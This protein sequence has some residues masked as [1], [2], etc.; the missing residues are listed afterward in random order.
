M[1]DSVPPSKP[2]LDATPS[3]PESE[4]PSPAPPPSKAPVSKAPRSKRATGRPLYFNIASHIGGL[5]V[6]LAAILILISLLTHFTTG[7]LNP[8]IGI[9][10]YMVFPALL[11]FGVLLFLLGMRWEAGR[12]KKLHSLD[13][14]PY[15][16]IDLNDEHQRRVF[17]YSSVGGV[18]V[19][20]LIVW[21][22]YQGFHFTES[23]YFCGQLCH[24]PMQPEFT[25]HRDSPHARVRCTECHVGEG[26]SW[27]VRSKL[28]GARQV[29]AVLSN[30]YQR[31]IPTP[32]PH[33]RPAR[34]TCEQ[35]HWPEKFFGATL[36]QLPHFR[37]TE[38]NDAEQ[39]SLTLK[40][41]G[42]SRA[43]GKSQ[44]IHWHMVVSNVVTYAASDAKLQVIPWVKV[45][46]VDGSEKTYVARKTK[47][48]PEKLE[49]LPKRQ[50]D[51]MDCHNRPA[52][53]FP[54]PDSG[55]DEALLKG[56]IPADLPW[57]K[58]ITVE[59]LFQEYPSQDAARDGIR[60]YI[61]DFYEH[62]YPKVFS[63]RKAELDN[64]VAVAN[65][66]YDRGVFPKM[67]VDWQ[68]YPVD[69]GHRYWPGCFRCHDGK[70]VAQDGTVLAHDCNST[71]HSAP[72]RGKVTSLGKVDE[73]ATPDWH[74]WRMPKEHL[75]IEGHDM[76]MCFQC[77]GAGKRPSKECNDCHEK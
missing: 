29:L 37:Y 2:E 25:A 45:R 57:V 7:T 42:G 55:I 4:P 14:L 50:M 68:T 1:S 53:T 10:T 16:K 71:C 5:V 11:G 36:L 67:N 66:I 6:V 19:A 32:V 47:L 35:C 60:R 8:Y 73:D 54:T 18:V 3:N 33:L 70:H 26:A 41:G 39:I 13:D 48:S 58:K 15:P 30:D 17:A 38:N 65:S 22:S 49:Q 24:V 23:I 34:E 61:L 44:G 43:H 20:T 46:H 62:Q 12:R 63:E 59:A 51:C 40:T 72:V 21:A 77:H 64:V 56:R 31:P 76:V 52:H 27:Y 9:F 69:L 75:D 28:S 74:P